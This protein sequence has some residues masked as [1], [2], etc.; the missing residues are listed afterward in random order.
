MI[1]AADVEIIKKVV[2]GTGGGGGFTITRRE[3]E[4]LFELNN[5]TA[6]KDNG[7]TWRELFVNAVGNYLMFPRGAPKVVGAEEL[8]RR[9]A[10]PEESSSTLSYFGKAFSAWMGQSWR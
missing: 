5:A 10:M 7:A 9:E 4:L 2:Y 3:A 6:D 1:D 8:R